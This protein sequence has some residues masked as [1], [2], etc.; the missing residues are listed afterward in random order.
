MASKGITHH[1]SW[2]CSSRG[3]WRFIHP[4]GCGRVNR[5]IDAGDILGYLKQL[6]I[7]KQVKRLDSRPE[8]LNKVAVKLAFYLHSHNLREESLEDLK[9]EAVRI[10]EGRVNPESVRKAVSE[11]IDFYEFLNEDD[12][13]QTTEQ[14][15]MHLLVD[16]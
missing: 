2:R 9:K 15:A 4:R 8:L 14:A 5:S 10:F 16:V 7:H 1:S 12:E 6:A 3:W 11:L 13:P